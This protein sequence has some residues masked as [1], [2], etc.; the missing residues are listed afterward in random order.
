LSISS[1]P[2]SLSYAWLLN[3]LWLMPTAVAQNEV[4]R[5]PFDGSR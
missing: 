5:S 2:F 4:A 1:K 3:Y